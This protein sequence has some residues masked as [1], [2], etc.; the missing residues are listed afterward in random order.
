MGDKVTPNQTSYNGSPSGGFNFSLGYDNSSL[1]SNNS[2]FNGGSG[3]SFTSNQPLFNTDFSKINLFPSKPWQPTLSLDGSSSSTSKGQTTPVTGSA[4]VSTVSTSTDKSNSNKVQNTKYTELLGSLESM[5]EKQKRKE[6]INNVIKTVGG[7]VQSLPNIDIGF[8]KSL[9]SAR[10]K[11]KD[12]LNTTIGMGLLNSGNPWAAGVGATLMLT[13]KLGLNAD[14]STN[15][16]GWENAGNLLLGALVPGSKA[17]AQKVGEIETNK[18]VAASSAYRGTATDVG[19]ASADSGGRFIFG[20]DRIS[21]K[22]GN[23]ALQQD[24]AFANL[25]KADKALAASSTQLTANKVQGQMAGGFNMLAA[26]KGAVLENVRKIIR[27]KR[28]VKRLN[29]LQDGGIVLR[30]M[31]SLVQYAD[32]QM[33]NFW[34]RTKIQPWFA[35]WDTTNNDGSIDTWADTHELEWMPNDEGEALVFSKIQDIDGKLVRFEDVNEALKNAV[36]RG[37]WLKMSQE[38]AMQ[39][40]DNYRN[41][42]DFFNTQY[43]EDYN[44]FIDSL[45]NNQ[46]YTPVDI[47]DTKSL[48]ELSGK[49]KTFQE[50]IKTGIYEFN[51]RDNS[52]HGKSVVLDPSNGHYLFLKPKTHPTLWMEEV[53][54]NGYVPVPKEGYDDDGLQEHYELIPMQGEDL[55]NNQNFRNRYRLDKSGDQYKYI[56][57]DPDIYDSNDFIE[58]YRKGGAFN[59]IPEGALHKNKHHLEEIDEKYKKVTHKGI[60]VITENSDGGIVQHAEVEKEEIIFRYEVTKK[61]EELNKK[62]TDEAAIEAGKLLVEE[63]LRN[64][65]DNTKNLL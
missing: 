61:L 23:A 39:F 41:T 58:S 62:G 6:T 65:I 22:I 44:L 14:A 47:Y 38:E 28:T 13:N 37:D 53:M 21:N 2:S 60:P 1:F 8:G 43:D 11:E 45:P 24:K 35:T 4:P 42:S 64:T 56:P 5:Q 19:K 15:G 20:S 27:K 63:I 25:E 3:S 9:D 57:I 36:Q 32:Q 31:D 51:D 49:P 33:P 30:D 46:K 26:K 18:R 48:W 10:G 54:Y 59:V 34:F 52:W 17:F 40:I 7:V 29:K 55:I 16:N 12:G 50:A